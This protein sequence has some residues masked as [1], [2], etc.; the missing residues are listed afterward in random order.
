M[1]EQLPS[2]ISATLLCHTTFIIIV[3]VVSQ[4]D[5]RHKQWKGEWSPLEHNI[6][7]VPPHLL[8]D[9]H[10]L[11]V[12][13]AVHCVPPLPRL[14]DRPHTYIPATLDFSFIVELF[15]FVLYFNWSLV[16]KAGKL[17]QFQPFT[18]I[19]WKLLDL[20]ESSLAPENPWRIL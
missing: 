6:S 10:R 5:S 7:A 16:L 17:A 1:A 8:P 11:P 12:C 4:G 9:C 14:S 2:D 3:P 19:L 18:S 15:P 13:F 20:I